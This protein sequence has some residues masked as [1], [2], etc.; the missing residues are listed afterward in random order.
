MQAVTLIKIPS[1]SVEDT[2]GL[3]SIKPNAYMF[4]VDQ[5]S[6]SRGFGGELNV[7]RRGSASRILPFFSLMI[8]L[9]D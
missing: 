3:F 1:G 5:A 2:M 8:P 4:V 6:A 9:D 7:Q